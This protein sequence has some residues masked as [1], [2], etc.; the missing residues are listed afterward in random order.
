MA[1]TTHKTLEEMNNESLAVVQKSNIKVILACVFGL[2]VLTVIKYG[3]SDKSFD[4]AGWLVFTGTLMIVINAVV[5]NVE[6]K[7]IAALIVGGM[8]G[9]I[10]SIIVGG[11]FTAFFI[12]Y[13][14]LAM[15]ALY[16]NLRI[17]KWTMIPLITVTFILAIVYPNAIE[18]ARGEVPG[19]VAK[20]VMLGMTYMM[21][22]RGISFRAKDNM[23][24]YENVI[25]VAENKD[26]FNDIA[27]ELNATVMESND[28][29]EDI[30]KKS[31]NI[32]EASNEISTDMDTIYNGILNVNQSVSI[33]RNYIEKNKK[34][35]QDINA[36]YSS[37]VENV[38]NGME[39]VELT[40]L[41]MQEME[42][43][44]DCSYENFKQLVEKMY[45]IDNSLE[46][47]DKIFSQTKLL[48]L[49]ASIEAAR[50]GE[51]G[52][53]FAVVAE[54]IRSLSD[55]SNK[56]ANNIMNIIEDLDET[57]DE[58]ALMM[59]D[60][61][62]V[63]NQG[64]NEVNRITAVLDGINETSE[65]V[66]EVMEKENELMNEINKEFKGIS[67]EITGLF[68]V[69]DKNIHLLS[70]VKNSIGEQNNAIHNLSEK[71]K[72]VDDMANEIVNV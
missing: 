24:V 55:E 40:K 64:Y 7:A 20:V 66:G 34:L 44:I 56:A 67:K 12:N 6:I 35:T 57:M 36:K 11:S 2:I 69:S 16:F 1:K 59:Q 37:V 14:V 22:R 30:V 9:N 70:T 26:K 52:K 38:N 65:I 51:N 42:K 8:S 10:Y 58:V 61:S 68:G 15:A 29:V 18:G 33:V 49:N 28:V 3:F 62:K 60:S 31:G 41:T 43:S 13:V 32:E 5:K 50:T 25:M 4:A 45:E 53:G 63:S 21:L 27:N 72:D 46:E 48:A 39:K 23:K 19:A 47:I 54:E 17:M 71:M